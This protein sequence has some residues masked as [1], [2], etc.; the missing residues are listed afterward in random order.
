VI[1]LAA[2]DAAARAQQIDRL[3]EAVS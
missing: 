2:A 3:L 1:L